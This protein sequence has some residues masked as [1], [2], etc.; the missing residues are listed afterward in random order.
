VRRDAALTWAF[1]WP[2]AQVQSTWFQKLLLKQGTIRVANGLVAALNESLDH[3]WLAEAQKLH[4]TIERLLPWLDDHDD[5]ANSPLPPA[6]ALRQGQSSSCLC[7]PGTAW[8]D[9]RHCPLPLALGEN[10]GAFS[11]VSQAAGA[12]LSGDT[13]TTVPSDSTSMVPFTSVL[14]TMT[15]APD[16]LHRVTCAGWP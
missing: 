12:C 2:A 13:V 5:E 15:C 14:N 11:S 6:P 10:Q 1:A 8:E 16:S 4:E 7:L 9:L 3:G